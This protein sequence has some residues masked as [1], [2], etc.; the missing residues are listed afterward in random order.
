MQPVILYGANFS[1]PSAKFPSFFVDHS[2]LLV[3]T[4]RYLRL[5]VP[6]SFSPTLTLSF[7]SPLFSMLYPRNVTGTVCEGN[8]VSLSVVQNG[9]RLPNECAWERSKSPILLNVWQILACFIFTFPFL[10]ASTPLV[11]ILPP[12]SSFP[13]RTLVAAI[14]LRGLR[15]FPS[16]ASR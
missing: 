16:D 5:F 7:H 1:N 3:F 8:A 9:V 11:P 2:V 13:S 4:F 14:Q 15:R 12:L 6:P 10:Y